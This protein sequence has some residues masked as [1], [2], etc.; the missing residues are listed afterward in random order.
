MTYIVHGATGAQGAPVLDALLREGHPVTGVA[1]SPEPLPAGAAAAAADLTDPRALSRLYRGAQGVF[2]HLPLGPAE[3]QSACAESIVA[4]VRETRPARVVVSTSGQI[5]DEPGSPLQAP[6][7]SPIMTLIRGLGETG[8]ALAIVAPRLFL[9]NLLLPVVAGPVTEEGVL[10]YPLA[11]DHAVS[12]SSH[13]DVAAAA[14]RLLVDPR[15]TGTVGVGALPA[16]TGPDLA[17]AFGAHHGRP[18]RYEAIAPAAFGDL[19]SPLLGPA[20]AEPV[21]GLYQALGT[22]D[23]TVITEDTSAQAVLGL[24]PLDLGNWLA[25]VSAADTGTAAG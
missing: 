25:E 15:I 19:I 18:V 16:L 9:E 1:R 2:A 17:A 10:R 7:D 21:V 5:V 14:A 20:A 24:R 3:L 12:W 13:A 6:D 23:R 8:T 22:Q 4:A 11:A